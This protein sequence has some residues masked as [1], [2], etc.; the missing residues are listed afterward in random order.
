[1]K[2][3]IQEELDLLLAETLLGVGYS[4][5]YIDWAL[6][7]MERGYESEN[8]YILASLDKNESYDIEKYLQKSVDDLGLTF[9][10]EEQ[11]LFDMYLSSVP[12][13]V[14]NG[15][16]HPQKGLAILE[17]MYLETYYELESINCPSVFMELAEDASLIGDYQI[18]YTGLTHE[19]LDEVIIDE[20]KMFFLAKERNIDDVL[21][22]IYCQKCNSFSRTV[23][24]EKGWFGI[25][26]WCCR[27][28][29]SEK[30]LAWHRVAD[31]KQILEMLETSTV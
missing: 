5:K 12:R 6:S 3:K 18:Y 23:Y 7:L 8:L 26:S 9:H 11:Y 20:M 28:C 29:D 30:Y 24:K 19:N 14:L 2:K 10:R 25:A 21:Q 16:M 1:M 22:L 17:K 13:K 31:R 4:S 15:E 27:N